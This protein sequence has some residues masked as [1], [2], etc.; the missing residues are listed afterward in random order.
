MTAIRRYAKRIVERFRPDAIYLFGSYANG[1][2]HADSDVD[3]MVVMP[4]RNPVDESVRIRLDLPATFPLDLL[5]CTPQK[6]QRRLDYGDSF[7]H[8]IAT[9]GKKLHDARNP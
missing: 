3:L 7:V 8:E 5:V 2:A 4:A 1:T 9:R 6:W